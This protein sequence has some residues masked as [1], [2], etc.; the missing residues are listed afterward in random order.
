MRATS[1]GPLRSSI[2]V[3]ATDAPSR[4]SSSAHAA[5]IP[6]DPP[7]ISATLPATCPAMFTPLLGFSCL[8]DHRR[9][10]VGHRD[11]GHTH[12]HTF[13]SLPTV[14]GERTSDM[15]LLAAILHQRIAE[16]LS[17]GAECHGVHHGAIT[18]L[19]AQPQMR[20]SH[21]LGENELVRRQRDHG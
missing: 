13:G 4:A 12:L 16:L 1:S 20:L 11:I 9:P 7:V 18:G 14:H 2:S 5:P 3:T 15:Q 17:H 21:L 6:D 19:Q 10:L 8:P